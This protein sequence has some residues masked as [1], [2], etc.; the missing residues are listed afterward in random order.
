MLAVQRAVKVI[1][2]E[3]TVYVLPALTL[4]EPSLHPLKVKPSRENADPLATEKVSP[5]LTAAWVGAVP[6]PPFKLYVIVRVG[7][8]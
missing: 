3:P 1:A 5:S 8:A 7:I 6:V 2:E 4:V